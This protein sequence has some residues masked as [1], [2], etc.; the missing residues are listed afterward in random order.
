MLIEPPSRSNP[1][2]SFDVG[3]KLVRVSYLA[4]DDVKRRILLERLFQGHLQREREALSEPS[5][6]PVFKN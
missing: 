1:S 3:P 4:A 5:T 6:K 2:V